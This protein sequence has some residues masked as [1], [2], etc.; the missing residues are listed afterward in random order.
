MTMVM[1]PRQRDWLRE[2]PVEGRIRNRLRIA[3]ILEG[4]D[5]TEVA[6]RS[7]LQDQYVSA[8]AT[9]RLKN[10]SLKNAQRIATALDLT[11]DEIFPGNEEVM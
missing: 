11:V 1:T 10:I 4:L 9:G 6:R 5:N 2:L 3:M 7:E 8:V